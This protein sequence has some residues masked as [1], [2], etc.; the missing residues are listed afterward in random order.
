M[1]SLV[2]LGDKDLLFSPDGAKQ[3]PCGPDLGIGPEIT[4]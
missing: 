1:S 2:P 3:L 4:Y